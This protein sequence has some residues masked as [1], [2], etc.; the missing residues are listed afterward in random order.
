[1]LV[2]VK[3]KDE[4]DLK[5]SADDFWDIASL[6][7]PRKKVSEDS[8]K[9]VSYDTNPVNFENHLSSQKTDS[10]TSSNASPFSDA[11]NTVHFIPPHTAEEWKRRPTPLMEYVPNNALIR[12]VKIYRW[13]SKFHFYERLSDDA[14]KLWDRK[15]VPCEK[16]PFFSYSPQYSQMNRAQFSYYLWWR[17]NAR[18]GVYL[19]ADSSY[20]M[21]YIYELIHLSETLPPE[22]CLHE[23]CGLWIRYGKEYRSVGRY[24]GEWVCD[25]CLIHQL[26]PPYDKLRPLY[27]DILKYNTLKE[28]YLFP[29]GN[30]GEIEIE[31][32]IALCGAYDYRQSKIATKER[33]P[34]MK[35]YMNEALQSLFSGAS[36]DAANFLGL[37][38]TPDKIER[39][40][41]SG[42]LSTEHINRH[43]EIEYCSISRSYEFRYLLS[44]IMKYSENK[45]R[46]LW[47]IRSRLSIYAL[48]TSIRQ[49]LDA[50][51][52]EQASQLRREKHAA[53]RAEKETIPE[54]E[55]K[56]DTPRE[57]F[58]FSKAAHIE[59]ASWETT[60][61]L[62]EGF[63]SEPEAPEPETNNESL[64][65]KKD[66]T[67]QPD[68]CPLPMPD[69]NLLNKE[70]P[71]FDSAAGA[72][73]VKAFKEKLGEKWNYLVALWKGDRG[74]A[75]QL[76]RAMGELPDALVDEINSIAVDCLGDIL[77]EE[78]EE[79][80]TVI[81]EYQSLLAEIV[82]T[83][84]QQEEKTNEYEL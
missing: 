16:V 28:F 38:F 26:Q 40:A 9:K 36:T 52:N 77:L 20:I 24:L 1:M 37:R 43:I 33:L 39:N 56:Y 7:P 48:P 25:L 64:L 45:L 32:W 30:L 6:L 63:S 72:V 83:K 79:G 10:A 74:Q 50:Y 75:A 42:A 46:A 44:D 69:P 17:E 70:K 73:P 27:D 18:Q 11:L 23:M 78:T 14:Q 51:F 29:K 82:R 35:K 67:L 15:G 66:D 21:L 49:Q 81:E 8:H 19:E 61:I 68:A 3:S 59:S 57:V 65:Q 54:Y 4:K 12:N 80:Y 13:Q 47:G 60:K 55:K 22:F 5:K 76:C 58:S 34:K 84:S 31:T 41:Y 62:V 71:D 53:E 2:S